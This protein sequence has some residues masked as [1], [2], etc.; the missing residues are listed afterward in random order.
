M[1]IVWFVAGA[2]SLAGCAQMRAEETTDRRV[3]QLPAEER[4]D[5]VAEEQ[6]I[7]AAQ[8]AVKQARLAVDQAR[9]FRGIARDEQHAAEAQLRASVKAQS[10][11]QRNHDA[12]AHEVALEAA[13]A[14]QAQLDSTQAK[15]SY[16][17]KL[18]DFQEAN[19]DEAEAALDLAR[20]DKRVA[21][22]RAL[23]RKGMARGIDPKAIE[24]GRSNAENELTRARQRKAETQSLMVQAQEEWHRR[25]TQQANMGSVTVPT[26]PEPTPPPESL[27]LKQP[28]SQPQ[29]QS[30]EPQDQQEGAGTTP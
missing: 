14:A 30:Q 11:A 21:G 9:Q 16:A 15:K 3:A 18:V 12:G 13:Q 7:A 26:P 6:K 23:E 24:R 5:E 22:L 29:P 4:G 27:P 1:R 8:T 20:A 19:V 17:D 25:P 28:E 2:L 10:L